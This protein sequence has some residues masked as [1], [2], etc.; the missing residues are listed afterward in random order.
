MHVTKNCLNLRNFKITGMVKKCL[1]RYTSE[2]C[3]R[4]IGIEYVWHKYG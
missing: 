1:T 4:S 3:R 2:K